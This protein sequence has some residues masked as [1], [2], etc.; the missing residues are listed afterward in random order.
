MPELPE[1]E[2]TVN[3]LK[4][5][6]VGGKIVAAEILKSG[7]VAEPSPAAFAKGLKGSTITD[8]SRRGKYLVFKLDNGK[9]LVAHLRMT[10]SFIVVPSKEESGKFVRVLIRL[11]NGQSLHFR[12]VRRFGKM[13]LVRDA[14]SVVGG[15]GIEPLS[16][17]FTPQTLEGLL[18]NRKTAIKS[19][20]LNQSLIAGIGNMY[21]DEALY[22]ARIHPLQPA[23]SLSNSEIKRLQAAIQQVLRQG[24]LNKGASTDTYLRPGGTKG[25]AH[26]L[27]EVAHQKGKSCGLCGGQV[28]RIVVGQRGTFFCP[29]CQKL[30]K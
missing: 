28:E 25:K 23:W 19:F 27:F 26:L 5:Q 14:G 22:A 12:D 21:A 10:G 9:W 4:P 6:V 2:T 17:D 8:L 20:L 24:I 1:V 18:R 3:D 15:L 13:W 16:P 29:K 30:H 7:T 11:D